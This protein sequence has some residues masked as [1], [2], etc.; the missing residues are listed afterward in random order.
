MIAQAK[1]DNLKPL[2]PAGI[3]PESDQTIV[4]AAGN[5]AVA[6]VAN[7]N[8]DALSA[9]DAARIYRGF[10]WQQVNIEHGR[11]NIVGFIVRAGLSELGTD[12][13]ITPEEALASGKP[14]NIAIVIGFWRVADPDLCNFILQSSGPGSPDKDKL[15][16]SFEVGFD[17]YDIVTLPHGVSNLAMATATITPDSAEFDR[18]DKLLRVNGGKGSFGKENARV[19]RIC[20]IEDY[21]LPNKKVKLWSPT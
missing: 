13:L 14:F 2:L 9:K 19:A 7:L 18:Y 20:R 3:D 8:D 12:R 1:L 5:L 21:D 17:D 4:Y 16:L 10:E 15:S 6:D 11:G